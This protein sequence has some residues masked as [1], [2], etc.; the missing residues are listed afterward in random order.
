MTKEEKEDMEFV[1]KQ[2]SRVLVG[3]II[4]TIIMFIV[5]FIVKSM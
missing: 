2:A 1:N 4:V 3:I 5:A